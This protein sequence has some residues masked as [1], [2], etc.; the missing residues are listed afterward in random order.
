MRMDLIDAT[1]LDATPVQ[2]V[3]TPPLFWLDCAGMI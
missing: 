3:H 2:Y 1:V